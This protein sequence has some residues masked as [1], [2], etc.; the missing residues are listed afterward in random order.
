MAATCDAPKAVEEVVRNAE[1]TELLCF[2]YVAEDFA[3]I[4]LLAF[5]DRVRVP[6]VVDASCLP[7]LDGH[8]RQQ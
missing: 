3:E 8:H 2:V 4:F 6:P 5:F 7:A 1:G